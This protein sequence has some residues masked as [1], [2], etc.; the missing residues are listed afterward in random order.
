M[1]ALVTIASC[2]DPGSVKRSPLET[3]IARDLTGRLAVPV[4]VQCHVRPPEM[5]CEAQLFDGTKLPLE[6]TPKGNG[7]DWRVAGLV[8]DTAPIASYIDRELAD[9][10]VAQHASCGTRIQIVQAGDRIGCRL[11]GGGMAFVRIAKDGKTSLEIALDAGAAAARGEPVT[12]A[13]EA[14]LAKISRSLE[15]L[16]GESDGEEAVPADGGRASP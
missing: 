10:R 13:R 9:L 15:A 14:E 5:Q 11:T 7:W 4:S 1:V 2:R 3:E 12:P 16:E 8:V 6:I